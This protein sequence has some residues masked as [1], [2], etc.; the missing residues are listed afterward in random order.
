MNFNTRQLRYMLGAVA[1][2]GVLLTT[3]AVYPQV[4]SAAE[5]T[6]IEQSVPW[7]GDR[8]DRGGKI[9]GDK[10]EFL[11][12]ALGITVEEL[13]AAQ[14]EALATG[15]QQAVDEGLI[16]QAQA[17]QI[18]DRGIG[19]GGSGHFG[20]F[21]SETIDP[22]ALLADALGITVEEL[23]AAQQAAQDAALAQA[24]E[25][26]VIT[27]EQAD[28]M[29]ARQAL[30]PYLSESAQSAFADAVAQALADGALT[31]EQADQLLEESANRFEHGM[32]FPGFG[33]ERGGRG[34]GG[35][36]GGPDRMPNSESAP[37]GSSNGSIT[38][39]SSNL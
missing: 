22:A 28:Q 33:G 26:G 34:H 18:Q 29:Q 4:T 17:D 19:R 8:G 37:E 15:L 14:A 6:P 25:E 27:Q 38:L 16:T 39:P 2:S 30:Q 1:V 11:A 5:D 10:S 32:K 23:D 24:V 13:E 21:Q 3:A 9:G 35:M 20:R 36:R 12:E 31:Q 7:R